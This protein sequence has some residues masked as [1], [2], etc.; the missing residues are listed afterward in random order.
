MS[1]QR[2]AGP[3][4]ALQGAL[5][6]AWWAALVLHPPLRARFQPP[7]S[8]PEHLLAFWL[9][10]LALV[11]AG[12]LLAA[13]LCARGGRWLLPA[14]WTVAGAVAYATLYCAALWLMTGA[15]W[16]SVALMLPAAALSL[17]FASVCDAP[18]RDV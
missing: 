17:L 2:L 9:P 15:A 3:Y 8:P 11:A 13:W 14:A 5:V 6:L 10:D 18:Q 7:G 1:F 12:S 4:F 16:L